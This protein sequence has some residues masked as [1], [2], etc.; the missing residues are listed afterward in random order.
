[1]VCCMLYLCLDPESS[2]WPQVFM[3]LGP[4][5]RLGQLLHPGRLLCVDIWKTKH[6]SAMKHET[7]MCRRK[8]AVWWGQWE[9]MQEREG[10]GEEICAH[11][12]WENNEGNAPHP[13]RWGGWVSKLPPPLGSFFLFCVHS[14]ASESA[15]SWALVQINH[16][17]KSVSNMRVSCECRKL[18]STQSKLVWSH[19]WSY[20]NS[21]PSIPAPEPAAPLKPFL[22]APAFK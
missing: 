11:K 22:V 1:M 18:L 4:P 20:C 17:R 14:A 9:K 8:E 3:V 19:P 7:C 2:T 16:L 5:L 6:Q 15:F 21:C 10:D 12:K 13:V